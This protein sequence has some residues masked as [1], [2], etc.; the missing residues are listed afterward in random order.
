[1]PIKVLAV[2]IGNR[3]RSQLAHALLRHY[4]RPA[5][6][7]VARQAAAPSVE[8]YSAGIRPKVLGP[9]GVH[10]L[11]QEVLAEIGVSSDGLYS[12]TIAEVKDS[13]P[14]DFVVSVCAEAEAQ[15]P[16]LPGVGRHLRWALPDP[17]DFPEAEYPRVFRELREELELRIR[18]FLAEL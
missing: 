11:V 13:G 2:C 12:K 4:A 16:V 14:F 17:G 10:P 8:V 6:G 5:Q 3:A 18:D 1:M 15:C 7:D 9:E